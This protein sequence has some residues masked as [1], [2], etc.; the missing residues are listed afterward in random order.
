MFWLRKFSGIYE[1]NIQSLACRPEIA[2]F[3]LFLHPLKSHFLYGTNRSNDKA[4][5]NQI[6]QR[7]IPVL[8]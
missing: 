8:V 6:F 2:F 4:S 3:P 1:I 7:N 5:G